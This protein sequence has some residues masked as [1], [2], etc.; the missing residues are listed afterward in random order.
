MTT[1]DRDLSGLGWHDRYAGTTQ[2]GSNDGGGGRRIHYITTLGG[3]TAFKLPYVSSYAYS[4]TAEELLQPHRVG[5][6]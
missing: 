6:A 1:Y 2:V 5:Q 3:F 4:R